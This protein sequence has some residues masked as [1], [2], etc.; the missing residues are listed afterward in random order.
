MDIF[1]VICFIILIILAV[2][3]VIKL[4]PKQNEQKEFVSQIPV[5]FEDM[6]G[7]LDNKLNVSVQNISKSVSEVTTSL[8]AVQHT[9]RELEKDRERKFGE[10]SNQLQNTNTTLANV[11]TSINTLNSALTNTQKRGAFGEKLADELLKQLGFIEKVHYFKQ[12]KQ[13]NGKIPDFTFMLENKL[14]VNMDSKFPFNN[15][16]KYLNSNSDIERKD[17]LHKF[18]KDV[19]NKIKD[20]ATKEYID[21]SNSTVDFA[22]IFIPSDAL[23]TFIMEEDYSVV[24]YAF[25]NKVVLCSPITLYMILRVFYQINYMFN[26]DKNVL[27]AIK[28]IE[29]FKKE[30][31]KYLDENDKFDVKLEEVLK[32]RTTLN[33]L[34]EKKLVDALNTVNAQLGVKE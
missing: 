24:E 21:T 28:Q 33:T 14:K 32:V 11:N 20:V 25:D 27:K 9:V 1:I 6:E 18:F 34:R 4:K 8:K 26:L 19:K 2:V 13:E 16:L 10:V 31:E 3:I 7:R 23:L 29:A 12:L 15:Y 17:Y 22:I 30:L 5:L